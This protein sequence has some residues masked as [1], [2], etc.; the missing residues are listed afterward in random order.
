[1]KPRKTATSSRKNVLPER[2]DM[3]NTFE[4][5]AGFLNRFDPEVEGRELQELPPEIQLKL[6]DLA[7]GALSASDRDELFLLLS[8]NP[9]WV[10]Q[11]AEEIK[12][13]RSGWARTDSRS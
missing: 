11:L 1:M 10:G 9:D 13:L 5:L 6:R 3:A 4:I 12:S 2:N 8:R 7:R